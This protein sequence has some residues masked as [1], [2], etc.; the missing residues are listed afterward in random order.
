[1]EHDRVRTTADK[2]RKQIC[3]RVPEVRIGEMMK[4]KRHDVMNILEFKLEYR[5]CSEEISKAP[6]TR[7]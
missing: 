3:L 2:V 6:E 7:T 4:K 1:L 5:R